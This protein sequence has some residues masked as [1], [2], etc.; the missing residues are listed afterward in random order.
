MGTPLQNEANRLNALKSTG[1]RS[2]EGK[3]VSR[4]NAI[5]HGLDAQS[6]VIPGEDF[7]AFEALAASY[8]QSL[9]PVGPIETFLVDTIIQA[10][11]LQR[12]LVRIETEMLTLRLADESLPADC[13]LG[14]IYAQDPQLK[15]PLH[16]LFQRQQA[17]ERRYYRALQELRLLQQQRE[18]TPPDQP[19]AASPPADWVRSAEIPKPVYTIAP[20]APTPASPSSSTSNPPT[21]P[22]PPPPKRG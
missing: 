19:E 18:S 13:P 3:A 9:R 14:A 6:L 10:D 22:V 15:S 11:W 16:K 17:A 21:P 1:P 4:F 5:R 20:I 2:A 12:R 8:R 7:A